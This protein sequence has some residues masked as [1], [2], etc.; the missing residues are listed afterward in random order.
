MKKIKIIIIL[1]RIRLLEFIERV[2]VKIAYKI[3]K[4]E[5]LPYQENRISDRIEIRR[6]YLYKKM[7]ALQ[8]Y[9]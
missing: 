5:G 1:N 8:L 3:S 4:L 9:G 6:S 7:R 2:I